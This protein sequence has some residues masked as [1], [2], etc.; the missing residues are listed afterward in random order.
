MCGAEVKIEEGLEVCSSNGVEVEIDK[1][2]PEIEKE[3]N[4]WNVFGIVGGAIGIIF[5]FVLFFYSS[6]L[7]FATFGGDFYSY[8]YLGI[9]KIF[10]AVCLGLGGISLTGGIAILS[11]FVQKNK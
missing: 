9:Y 2:K 11:Y 10:K 5:G 4:N 3:K 6:S 1:A 7:E 8:T